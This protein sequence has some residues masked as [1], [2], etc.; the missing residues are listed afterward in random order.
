MLTLEVVAGGERKTLTF[1]AAFDRRVII[2]RSAECDL[3]VFDS[4]VSRKNTMLLA[5]YAGWRVQDLG[6]T[7]GTFL[8]GSKVTVAAF[9]RGD[10]V[11]VGATQIRLLDAEG[12]VVQLV[13]DLDAGRATF[14][15]HALPLSAAELIWFGFL[16]SHRARGE[17][18]VTAG[19]DGHPALAQ[20]TQRLLTRAWAREVKTRPLL[21]LARG[22][23]VDDEDLKNL[24]GK[25]AQKLK[26]FCAGEREWMAQLLVPQ[27]Q[28]RN[29][30]RLPLASAAC[31]LR[32]A[33]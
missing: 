18:W 9:E 22:E 28:G 1:D 29:R 6:S 26:A 27:V 32:G 7:N 5:T 11:T 31:V 24:R 15:E 8:N 16:A 33:P 19:R 12:P 4:G 14:A 21:E 17:G 30:Q 13:L 23:E 20:W 3:V 2:G 10:V 25:T